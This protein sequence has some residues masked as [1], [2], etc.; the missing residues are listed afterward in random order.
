MLFIPLV[1]S[2]GMTIGYV[3]GEKFADDGP[4][5]KAAAIGAMGLSVLL[6]FTIPMHPLVPFLMQFAL[7][8][9]ILFRYRP[10]PR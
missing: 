2:L 5:W 4:I 3:Y 10:W 8:V 7:S 6:E 1:I 9:A